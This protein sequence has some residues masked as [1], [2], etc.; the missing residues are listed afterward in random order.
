[1]GI[2]LRLFSLGFIMGHAKFFVMK[3]TNSTTT[4]CNNAQTNVELLSSANRNT[5]G[6][7]KRMFDEI[8]SVYHGLVHTGQMEAYQENYVQ[9]IDE[10]RVSSEVERN[11]VLQCLKAAIERRV[12]EVK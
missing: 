12:S 7:R 3:P 4:S 5:Y 1:M 9:L 11:R 8:C 10:H 2:S 6:P